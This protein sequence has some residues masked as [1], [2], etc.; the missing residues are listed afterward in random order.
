MKRSNLRSMMGVALAAGLCVLLSTWPA[1][2]EYL[3]D[4]AL[5]SGSPLGAYRANC[6]Y[7]SHSVKPK[8]GATYTITL[9]SQ[10][11][12]AY[13]VL[14]DPFGNIV[15]EDDDSGGNLDA[16]ITHTAQVT[17]T[18]RIIATTFRPFTVGRYRLHVVP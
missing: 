3:T 15:A 18:Y 9:R 10:Q 1:A 2:A 12:D 14:V 16:L 7:R 13:L 5:T 4:G 8:A 6:Y 11:F 17:G